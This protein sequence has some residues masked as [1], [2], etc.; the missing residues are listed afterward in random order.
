MISKIRKFATEIRG[1]RELSDGSE[2]ACPSKVRVRQF[3]IMP[4]QF[5]DNRPVPDF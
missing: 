4:L 5:M 2:G 3:R 1:F